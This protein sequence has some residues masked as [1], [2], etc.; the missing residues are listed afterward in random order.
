[1]PNNW[2]NKLWEWNFRKPKSLAYPTQ[3]KFIFK[4]FDCYICIQIQRKLIGC[5]EWFELEIVLQV[6]H[7]ILQNILYNSSSFIG[8]IHTQLRFQ[9]MYHTKPFVLRL[10]IVCLCFFSSLIFYFVVVWLKFS[11]FIYTSNWNETVFACRQSFY[12]ISIKFLFLQLPR[13]PPFHFI[14]IPTCDLKCNE[15]EIFMPCIHCV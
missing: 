7:W 11:F 15:K 4:Q 6:G 2:A 12:V 3:N 9:K 14:C 8:S 10:P 5:E 13:P 1:M